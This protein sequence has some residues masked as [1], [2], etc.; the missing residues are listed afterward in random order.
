MVSNTEC[1]VHCG[2]GGGAKLA[3]AGY[4]DTYGAVMESPF[5]LRM[6]SDMVA[7]VYRSRMRVRRLL[8]CCCLLERPFSV[9]FFGG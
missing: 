9:Q 8:R 5:L 7:V 1:G 2:H 6:G 3:A 4:E